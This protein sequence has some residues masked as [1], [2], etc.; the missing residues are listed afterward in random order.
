MT[1]QRVG[2]VHPL[3]GGQHIPKAKG[4]TQLSNVFQ[5]PTLLKANADKNL[6]LEKDRPVSLRL[7]ENRRAIRVKEKTKHK[8]TGTALGTRQ[9]K[10]QRRKVC[11]TC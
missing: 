11:G 4:L 1:E 6:V 10:G 3:F 9:M 8:S 2:Q 5:L 7:M